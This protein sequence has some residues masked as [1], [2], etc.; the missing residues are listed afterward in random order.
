MPLETTMKTLLEHLKQESTWRGLIAIAMAFG[1]TITPDQQ[2]AIL[3]AGLA[4]IG[5]INT[6]KR[7]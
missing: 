4:V 2:N 1:L 5:L 7:D 3:A 6:V